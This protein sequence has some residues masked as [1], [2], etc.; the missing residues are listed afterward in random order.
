MSIGNTHNYPML[1]TKAGFYASPLY[2]K[3]I[4]SQVN[5]T[6]SST[7]KDRDRHSYIKVRQNKNYPFDKILVVVN[8]SKFSTVMWRFATRPMIKIMC[9][10]QAL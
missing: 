1:I 8:G 2:N 3:L 4:P 5:P 9:Q 10:S 6:P 7:Q